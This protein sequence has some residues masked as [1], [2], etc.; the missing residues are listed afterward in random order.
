MQFH[1]RVTS[2]CDHYRGTFTLL[3]TSDGDLT[4]TVTEGEITLTGSDRVV[5]GGGIQW[6]EHGNT[7]Y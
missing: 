5:S 6:V 4:V 2:T 7:K 3:G 1:K